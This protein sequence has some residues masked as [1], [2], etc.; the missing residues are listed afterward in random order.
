MLVLDA[1][2]RH[3]TKGVEKKLHEETIDLVVIPG[4]MTG[5][6]QPRDVSQKVIQGPRERLLQQ[7]DGL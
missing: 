1:F 5:Q 2:R 7:V 4:G 6:L 3:L